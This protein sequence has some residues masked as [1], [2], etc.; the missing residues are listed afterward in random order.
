MNF[1]FCVEVAFREY[2][3][4]QLNFHLAEIKALINDLG[5]FPET[6]EGKEFPKVKRFSITGNTQ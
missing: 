2:Q 4:G 3:F 5:Y 1:N 6:W